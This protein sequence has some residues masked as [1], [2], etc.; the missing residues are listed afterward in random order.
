MIELTTKSKL[1]SSY[2]GRLKVIGKLRL[3]LIISWQTA[4][5]PSFKLLGKSR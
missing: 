3:N 4:N 5:P 2:D 1:R